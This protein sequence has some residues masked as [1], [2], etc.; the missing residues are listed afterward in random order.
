[1]WSCTESFCSLAEEVGK[2]VWLL[3]IARV[4]PVSE[5]WLHTEPVK[6]HIDQAIAWVVEHSPQETDLEILSVNK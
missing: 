3:K 1:V 4:I 2:G 5:A 6:S